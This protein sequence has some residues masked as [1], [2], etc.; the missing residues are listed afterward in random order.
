MKRRGRKKMTRSE[1]MQKAKKLFKQTRP[2]LTEKQIARKLNVTIWTVR[3]YKRKL[4]LT[5]A[6]TKNGKR[7]GRKKQNAVIKLGKR[8]KRIIIELK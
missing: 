7:L 5:N 3:D 4:G 6:V 8:I 1:R 2:K